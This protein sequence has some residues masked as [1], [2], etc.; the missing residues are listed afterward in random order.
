ML[1]APSAE[2]GQLDPR[3]GALSRGGDLFGIERAPRG[4]TVITRRSLQYSIDSFYRNEKG[5]Y[6]E[7]YLFSNIVLIY[8]WIEMILHLFRD[9]SQFEESS[10]ETRTRIRLVTQIETVKYDTRRSSTVV[11]PIA[12]APD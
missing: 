2:K 12:R 11:L 3:R 6:T 7:H 10:R 8:L 4:N 5:L 1:A 9:W